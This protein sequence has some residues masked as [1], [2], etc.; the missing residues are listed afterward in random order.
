MFTEAINYYDQKDY[1]KAMRLLDKATQE[2]TGFVEAY[3]LKG[4]SYQIN[5]ISMKLLPSTKK[6]FPSVLISH[7]LFIILR[8]IW[9]L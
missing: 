6:Q 2:D 7:H 8:L 4:I 9:N 5:N 3:I 1:Q